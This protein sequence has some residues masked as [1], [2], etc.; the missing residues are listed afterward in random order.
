MFKRV[1]AAVFLV[2]ML[3]AVTSWAK[4][5]PVLPVA[6]FAL[7]DQQGVFHQLSYRRDL[8]AIVIATQGGNC[9]DAN[10]QLRAF[11]GAREILSGEP[12]ILYLLN[13][14]GDSREAVEAMG[15][16]AGTSVAVLLDET[17]LVAES[18]S[19][20]NNG[21][22]L[23]IDPGSLKVLFRGL[24]PQ[25]SED[26]ATL[27]RKVLSSSQVENPDSE[28]TH[29]STRDICPIAFEAQPDLI[30]YQKDIVPIVE[31]R[32]I[33]CHHENGIA[34]WAMS[35]HAMLQGWAPMMRE[36]VMTKRMPPG[37]IDPQ[38]GKFEG[39]NEITNTE[40]RLLVEWINRG[41]N[42]TGSDDPLAERPPVETSWKLGE[43]DILVKI[44]RQKIPATGVVDYV[45]LSLDLGLT[46]DVYVRGF[47][48]H[49]QNRK[50][51]HH[52]TA[53]IEPDSIFG[54]FGR[55]LSQQRL[56]GYAPGRQPTHYP[57]DTG[58][59]FEA[60]S[61]LGLQ[62][63]YTT[64]GKQASDETEVGLYLWDKKPKH[65]MHAEGEVKLLFKIPPGE[66]EHQVR[67]EKTFDKDVY[68]YSFTPHMHFRGKAMRYTAHYP[69]GRSEILLSVPN[70]DF[71]WQMN[72]NLAEPKLLPSGTVMEVSGSFDNSELNPHNPDATRQVWF[73]LQS[74]DEMFIGF[75]D[76]REVGS[77]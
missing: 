25:R 31:E 58:K 45:N 56:G 67:T 47:E 35:S 48:I 68:L 53:N 8:S 14:N 49:P 10:E 13:A 9:A 20:R 76:Y 61:K 27:V 24:T 18:L 16:K 23:I 46:E 51:L 4:N 70:Y 72:Y 28:E 39:V 69:D 38:Y 44:P 64:Y 6:D 17:Q 73:G 30:S 36:V 33:G 32:C 40:Q 62:L 22:L 37:Q 74:W 63:H 59:L 41:A 71:N 43:P 52:V 3:P 57:A 54:A 12:T 19:F 50:V 77:Q 65:E 5:A 1:T 60:D 34:P 11:D 26:I 29:G 15:E 75:L 55:F 42:T 66:K 7:L 21:E 2:A